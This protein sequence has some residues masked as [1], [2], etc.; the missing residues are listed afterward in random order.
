MQKSFTSTVYYK[1]DLHCINIIFLIQSVSE[2][3]TIVKVSGL[4]SEDL[5][6]ITVRDC[7]SFIEQGPYHPVLCVLI[8]TLNT[9]G[10]VGFP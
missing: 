5:G 4:G 7:E 2:I 1:K 9:G 10:L 6:W 8:I 3:G